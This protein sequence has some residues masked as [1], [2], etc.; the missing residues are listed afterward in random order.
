MAGSLK[1]IFE[2]NDERASSSGSFSK[3]EALVDEVS[4]TRI[5]AKDINLADSF[6]GEK[7]VVVLPS[8]EIH[9]AGGAVS[10]FCEDVISGGA[11]RGA[12]ECGFGSGEEAVAV[13]LGGEMELVRGD[14]DGGGAEQV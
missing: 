7:V 1:G 13:G 5:T 9:D 11:V 14:C 2:T 4:E 3:R 12:G 10:D 6:H 8:D